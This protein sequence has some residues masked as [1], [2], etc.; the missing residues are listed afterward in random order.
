MATEA[1]RVPIWHRPE[2]PRIFGTVF[3]VLLLVGGVGV[4]IQQGVC[5]SNGTA[6]V[7]LTITGLR[8]GVLYAM[9]ALGYTMVY[10]VLQLLNF[11]HSEIFMIGS[12]AGLYTLSKLFNI[13][14]ASHPNGVGGFD[15]IAAVG[16]ALIFAAMAS[17]IAAVL[18]ERIA[19]R[20]LRRRGTSR[21]GYLITAIGV[22]L[23]LQN[24]FL[25]M[26]GGR[27]LGLPFNWPKIAGPGPVSYPQPLKHSTVFSVA[28]V[29]VDALTLLI[30]VVAVVMLIVLD[31]FVRISRTG[32]QIRAVAEDPTTATIMGVNVDRVIIITFFVGGL[33]AGAAGLFYGMYFTQ[34]QFNMGFIPGIKAFTAAVLGGIGN[35]RGAMLGGIVLGLVENLGVA[36]VGTQWQ[37]VIAFVVLVAVLMFRPT[38]LLGER[39]GVRR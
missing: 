13:N 34:A 23:F 12:F 9:V 19:Y 11:A 26:D 27:H 5:P 22:S 6:W 30:M 21:L 28:G 3:L 38:G 35:I 17:G 37:S 32:K 25:L 24:L 16:V 31:R 20:P 2:T 4:G 1:G 7:A 29:P 15:L 36:C 18:T 10:G 14:S 39:V 33:M 8:L